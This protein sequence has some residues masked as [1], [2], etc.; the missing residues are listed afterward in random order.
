[1]VFVLVVGSALGWFVRR[2]RVQRD[3]V[4]A[5]KSIGGEAVY[6][7]EESRGAGRPPGL[8]RWKRVIADALGIDFVSSVTSVNL[9]ATGPE[10]ERESALACLGDFENLESA[11][12]SGTGVTDDVCARLRATRNLQMLVLQS[13]AVTDAGLANLESLTGLRS[14]VILHSGIT[15]AGLVHLKGLT[16]LESLGI[17]GA[18]VTD[19]GLLHLSGLQN[20]RTLVLEHSELT[21]AGI[22][23]LK[24]LGGLTQLHLDGSGIS[25]GG[26]ADLEEALPNAS[27]RNSAQGGTSKFGR[28]LT[29][30][31]QRPS[32]PK[33]QTSLVPVPLS[34]R[35]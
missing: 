33:N 5:V 31:V 1:M 32:T 16:N 18:Q 10:S 30:K 26:I 21:D 19:A 6:D 9:Y 3:A 27:V 25:P 22:P 35:P 17:Y 7:F 28:G 34:T 12:L 11:Y 13:T 15:D 4:A 20:L 8:P 29:V 24:R 2:A 23:E 14:L